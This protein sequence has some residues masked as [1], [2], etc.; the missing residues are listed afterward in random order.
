M[1]FSEKISQTKLPKNICD[2]VNNKKNYAILVKSTFFIFSKFPGAPILLNFRILFKKVQYRFLGY[3][4]VQ[5]GNNLIGR[6]KVYST[7]KMWGQPRPWGSGQLFL[8]LSQFSRSTD[9][10]EKIWWKS[11]KRSP[12]YLNFNVSEKVK[13]EK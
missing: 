10:P 6:S 1:V 11:A 12:S 5:F 3:D 8:H 13:K 7:K 9:N 2:F 4:P